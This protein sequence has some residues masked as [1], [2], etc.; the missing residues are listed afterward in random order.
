MQIQMELWHL[1]TLLL[2]FFGCVATFGKVLLSMHSKSLDEKFASQKETFNQRFN[3]QDREM[4]KVEARIQAMTERMPNEYVRRE[5]W[6][7]FSATIDAKLDTLHRKLDS[8]AEKV[9]ARG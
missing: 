3:T 8:M 2:A 4:E 5:D 7:R 6:I 9:Y 1:I